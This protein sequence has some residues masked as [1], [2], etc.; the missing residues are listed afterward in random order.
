MNT[1]LYILV[2]KFHSEPNLKYYSNLVRHLSRSNSFTSKFIVPPRWN[3]ILT[4]PTADWKM[5]KFFSK[6][7]G[8]IL[9]DS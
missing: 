6:N 1:L 2:A 5:T 9:I 4:F 8:T 7:R 3:E